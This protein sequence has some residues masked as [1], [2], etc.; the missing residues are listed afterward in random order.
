MRSW[1]KLGFGWPARIAGLLLLCFWFGASIG[2]D[3]PAVPAQVLVFGDSLSA[4]YQLPTEAG[5][6]AGLR[7][8]L[9]ER[10]PDRFEVTNASVSGET[11]SGGLSR[12]PEVLETGDYDWV[13]LELGANDGLRGLPLTRIEA[14]LQSLIDRVEDHG[15]RVV[16]LGIMLP[17][18]Y[19][20]AYAEPFAA[21]YERLAETN[22]LPVLPFLLDG[23]AS[24]RELMMDDGIH[25]N[26]EGQERVLEN[27]WGV[28]AP[29]WELDECSVQSN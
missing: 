25:P 7:E 19:G 5:W 8:R 11:T 3:T 18:N 24:E 15:A 23:V 12:L 26:A 21:M 9:A 16:L 20:P 17:T 27:V 14:N 6:V 2:D 1:G 10:A 22:G 4:A 29:L 13:L 28:V